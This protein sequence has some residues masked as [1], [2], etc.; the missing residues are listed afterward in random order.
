VP[1][2]K[3]FPCYKEVVG[4]L[5]HHAGKSMAQDVRVNVTGWGSGHFL[6][7]I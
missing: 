4:N 2:K 1:K 3:V 7:S 5:Q 6:L